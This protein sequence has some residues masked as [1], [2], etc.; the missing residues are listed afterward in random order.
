MEKCGKPEKLTEAEAYGRM[1]DEK[2]ARGELTPQEAEDE[3]QDF[4]LHGEGRYGWSWQ[5]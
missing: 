2:V 5:R 4:L 3:Y 1:L